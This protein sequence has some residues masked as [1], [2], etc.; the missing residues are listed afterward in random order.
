MGLLSRKKAASP[1]PPISGPLP[2]TNVPSVPT[3]DYNRKQQQHQQQYLGTS[4]AYQHH[5]SDKYG[6]HREGSGLPSPPGSPVEAHDPNCTSLAPADNLQYSELII[7]RLCRPL[8]VQRAPHP[9]LLCPI[10]PQSPSPSSAGAGRP[11]AQLVQF[12]KVGTER[13]EGGSV[14]AVELRRR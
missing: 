14:P 5:A 9:A 8:L 10:P 7:L 4:S 2:S 11:F 13:H 12:A 1:A 6:S 3:T